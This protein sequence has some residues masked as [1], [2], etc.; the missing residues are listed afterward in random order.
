MQKRWQLSK[1]RFTSVSK[2]QWS[3]VASWALGRLLCIFSLKIQQVCIFQGN[4]VFC[5]LLAKLCSFTFIDSMGPTFKK[6]SNVGR[7]QSAKN[8][9]MSCSLDCIV[10][11]KRFLPSEFFH[12]IFAEHTKKSDGNF[13][14]QSIFGMSVLAMK[15]D[16]SILV[17]C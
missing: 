17:F 10:R 15:Y 7:W 14:L 16:F 12:S 11:F 8:A 5:W 6:Y 1:L 2:M 3:V 9:I 4:V 13:T